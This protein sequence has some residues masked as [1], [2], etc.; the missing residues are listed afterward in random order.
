MTERVFSAGGW[1]E[2]VEFVAGMDGN[3][4][5]WEVGVVEVAEVVIVDGVEDAVEGAVESV[6]VNRLV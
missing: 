6:W 3:G 1:K 4:K 5:F 2:E